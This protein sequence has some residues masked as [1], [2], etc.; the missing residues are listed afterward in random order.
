MPKETQT[1]PSS[2]NNEEGASAQQTPEHEQNDEEMDLMEQWAKG[3][4]EWREREL[5]WQQKLEDLAQRSLA[6]GKRKYERQQQLEQLEKPSASKKHP[7]RLEKLGQQLSASGEWQKQWQAQAQARRQLWEQ[8]ERP[9]SITPTEQQS[10]TK[11]GTSPQSS[12]HDPQPGNL[13]NLVVKV[14]SKGES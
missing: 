13:D 7:Q 14:V 4:G 1:Q 8:R 2:S 9:Q 12:I 6:S 3:L 11:E 10:Q 5:K